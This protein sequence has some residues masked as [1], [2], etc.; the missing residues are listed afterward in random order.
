MLTNAVVVSKSLHVVAELG[1]ADHITDE[2]VS[3]K[4][5]APRPTPDIAAVRGAVDFSQFS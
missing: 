1:V 3:I 4:V 5:L 2:T